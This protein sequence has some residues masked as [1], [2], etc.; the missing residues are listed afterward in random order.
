MNP[1]EHINVLDTYGH[2]EIFPLMAEFSRAY[3]EYKSSRQKLN[4]L[5]T[6]ERE[7]LKRMDFFKF[8]MNEIDNANLK[9]DAVDRKSVV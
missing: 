4:S 7:N 2:T 1:D 8:E 6:D 3:E 9:L 5:I